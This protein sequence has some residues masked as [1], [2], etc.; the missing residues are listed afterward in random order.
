MCT[1]LHTQM[2]VHMHKKEIEGKRKKDIVC[3][4]VSVVYMC[5]LAEVFL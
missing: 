4:C 1:H 2:D 3:V 5:V